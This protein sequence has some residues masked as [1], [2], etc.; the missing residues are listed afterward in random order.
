MAAAL[1]GAAILLAAGAPAYHAP[2]NVFGQPDLEG[3]W[4]NQSLTP[5]E[6][7]ASNTCRFRVGDA[8]KGSLN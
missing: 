4:T 5:V 1:V 3:T 6:R 8:L 7:P 2:R